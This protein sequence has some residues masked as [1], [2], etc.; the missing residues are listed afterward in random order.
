MTEKERQVPSGELS[1]EP[2]P[3]SHSIELIDAYED[4]GR[5]MCSYFDTNYEQLKQQIGS[6]ETTWQLL[7]SFSKQYADQYIKQC[8][9]EGLTDILSWINI[10]LVGKREIFYYFNNILIN[11]KTDLHNTCN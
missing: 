10:F 11:E 4:A 3:L 5:W 8:N 9:T 1:R 7:G 6:R 2:L